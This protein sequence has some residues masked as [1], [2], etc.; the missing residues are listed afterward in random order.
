MIVDELLPYLKSHASGLI[1]SLLNG[2]Y[3]PQPVRWIE[4]PKPDGGFR[5]VVDIDLEKFFDRVNHDILMHRIA[6]RVNDKG[7]FNLNTTIY[8]TAR[9]L[10][11]LYKVES[12][13]VLWVG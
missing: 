3:K 4:I 7:V 9:I 2:T 11:S 6:K 8:I 13:V 5:V 10:K 12:G 1:D